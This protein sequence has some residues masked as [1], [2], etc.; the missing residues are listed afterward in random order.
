MVISAAGLTS[1]LIWI[2]QIS[3]DGS[4]GQVISI[5]GIT[6]PWGV[7]WAIYRKLNSVKDETE[8]YLSDRVTSLTAELSTH[9]ADIE[10]CKA[11]REAFRVEN[12]NLKFEINLRDRRIEHL[13]SELQRVSKLL[14]PPAE[15][16]PGDQPQ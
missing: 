2:A 8:K 10:G 3:F 6:I 7:G 14:D 1:G 15:E 16:G 4:V 5:G 11:D 9:S 13:E 12:Y